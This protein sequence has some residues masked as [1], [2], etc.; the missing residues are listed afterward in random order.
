MVVNTMHAS[1]LESVHGLVCRLQY[2]SGFCRGYE[3][4]YKCDTQ[5]WHPVVG[6]FQAQCDMN[7]TFKATIILFVGLRIRRR[8]I[9]RFWKIKIIDNIFFL[10]SYVPFVASVNRE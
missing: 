4:F 2:F 1:A 6:K 8:Q 3:E 9:S 5:G 7:S 10:V